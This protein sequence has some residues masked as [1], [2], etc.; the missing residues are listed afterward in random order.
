[1]HAVPALC[2]IAV[3][4]TLVVVL[5]VPASVSLAGGFEL[6]GAEVGPKRAYFAGKPVKISYRA[7]DEQERRHRVELIQKG[8]RN[9]VAVWDRQTR[10]EGS[11]TRHVIRW[12]GTT[13]RGKVAPEGRYVVRLGPEGRPTRRIGTFRF[14]HHMFP[15]VG[16]HH[17]RGYLGEF[18]APRSGGRVHEGFDVN[19]DCGTKIV[20][21]RGGRVL[22]SE[23]DPRLRGNHVVIKGRRDR[24]RYVYAHLRDPSPMRKGD[25]V[26]T[27][28]LVGRVG[29]TGNA[30]GTPCHL[31]IELRGPNGPVDPKP[32]L[33][34]WDR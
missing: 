21:A 13:R 14:R 15:L 10:G 19:A 29:L 27:G 2:L 22:R 7:D 28:Q 17:D 16:P 3:L 5:A 23:L 24:F 31:H 26:R 1:M 6:G 11:G 30:A 32:H 34:R 12:A 9:V 4:A 33:R 25:R 18:G 8:S 20:A